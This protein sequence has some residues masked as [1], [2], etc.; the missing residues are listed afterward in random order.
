VNPRAATVPLGVAAATL[1]LLG[2]WAT[3]STASPPAPEITVLLSRDEPPYRQALAGFDTYLQGQGI[4]A[5][6]A[7]QTIERGGADPPSSGPGGERA[8]PTLIFALGSPATRV[9]MGFGTDSPP[10]VAGLILDGSEVQGAVNATGVALEFPPAI[11]LDWMRR[12]VPHCK[13]VGVLY[14]PEQNEARIRAAAAAVDGMGLELVAREVGSPQALPGALKS[15]SRS[16]DVLWGMPD[17]IVLSPEAARPILL[18]S[19]RNRIPF[20]GASTAWVKAGALFCLTWDYQDIGAQCGEL[21][22]KLLRGTAAADLPPVSPRRVL[23]ALNLK[24]AQQMK[25]EFSEEVVRG[26]HEVFE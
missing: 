20:V 19:F 9:A 13:R 17:R 10:L 3:V 8:R 18:F 5:H 6:L 1:L 21:A 16:I 26:A 25:I 23:Y 4:G 7:V 24:T 12:L 2:G 15:L 22:G 14:N 11:S